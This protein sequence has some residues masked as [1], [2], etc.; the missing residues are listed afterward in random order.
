M[1]FPH[2]LQLIKNNQFDTIYHEI[3]RKYGFK[4]TREIED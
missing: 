3:L 4:R 1:E 2:L